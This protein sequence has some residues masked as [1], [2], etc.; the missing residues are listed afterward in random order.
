MKAEDT[1]MSKEQASAII[2]KLPPNELRGYILGDRQPWAF[3]AKAQAEISFKAGIKE[4]VKWIGKYSSTSYEHG[5]GEIAFNH[6][7]WHTKLKEW[8]IEQ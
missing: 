4:V 8:G 1:V 7:N 6:V 3:I 5:K 2:D